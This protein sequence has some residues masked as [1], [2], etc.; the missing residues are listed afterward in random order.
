MNQLSLK[1]FSASIVMVSCA[2][3][4]IGEQRGYILGYQYVININ[5]GVSDILEELEDIT[6]GVQIS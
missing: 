1:A 2:L 6:D 4:N 3:R 5:R